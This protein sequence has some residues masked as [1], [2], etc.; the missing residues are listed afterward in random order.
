[1]S[2]A[3][4]ILKIITKPIRVYGH[5][6]RDIY[7]GNVD[8]P[9]KAVPVYLFNSIL[10]LYLCATNPS[11]ATITAA[12]SVVEPVVKTFVKGFRNNL[13]RHLNENDWIIEQ[14]IKERR[15]KHN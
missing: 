2:L 11:P 4:D 1:M 3:T 9:K 15:Y 10:S 6:C 14:M 5:E 7:F 12:L 8:E 13:L